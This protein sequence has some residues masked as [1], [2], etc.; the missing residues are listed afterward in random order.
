[1][2]FLRRGLGYGEW[3]A[4]DP[5]A[6]LGEVEADGFAA[7]QD[8][9]EEFSQVRHFFGVMPSAHMHGVLNGLKDADDVRRG[10]DTR[11]ASPIDAA[12]LRRFEADEG[13]GYKNLSAIGVIDL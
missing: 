8:R 6:L 5:L 4:M 1:M 11:E 10:H 13:V 7:E 9:F 2:L 12:R 3:N